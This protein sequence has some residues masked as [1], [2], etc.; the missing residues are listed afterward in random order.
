MDWLSSFR[1]S[2][3]PSVT[4]P[5]NHSIGFG[6]A[7]LSLAEHPEAKSTTADVKYG[8]GSGANK[9]PHMEEQATQ[10]IQESLPHAERPE[11][12]GQK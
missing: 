5:G 12:K 9:R 6:V 1:K 10:Q 2:N 8:E 3:K 4:S 7:G 11:R